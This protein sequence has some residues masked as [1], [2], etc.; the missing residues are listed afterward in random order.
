MSDSSTNDDLD[1]TAAVPPG[2][3]ESARRLRRIA[4]IL[5]G[6]AAILVAALAVLLFTRSSGDTSLPEYVAPFKGAVPLPDPIAAPRQLFPDV[7]GKTVPLVKTSP[8]TV[9]VLFFGYTNCPDVCP[10][11]MT[12]LSSALKDLP[13]ADRAK[14]RVT[15]ATVDPA[16]DTPAELGSWLG[17]LSPS[18]IG[19]VPTREASN[20]VLKQMGYAKTE[21]EAMPDGNGYAVSHPGAMF[22][23]TDDGYAH[24]IFTMNNA[25]EQISADL[26]KLLGGW[27]K[28][29]AQ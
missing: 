24:V 8:G 6:V 2:V 19:L 9:N 14:V 17:K 10:L 23:F 15:F 20:A 28:E 13:T 27:H 29:Y 11:S 22:V 5:T 4:W 3:D 7:S 12:A 26:R 16:R 1:A 25:P 21:R 18:F